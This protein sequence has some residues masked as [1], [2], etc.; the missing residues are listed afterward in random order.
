MFLWYTFLT[1]RQGW[2]TQLAF[3][4]GDSSSILA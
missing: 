3:L 1:Q 4:E 2:S